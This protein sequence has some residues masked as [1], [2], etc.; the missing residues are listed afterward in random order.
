MPS[1]EHE[2]LVE[3]FTRDPNLAILL[4]KASKQVEIPD[5]DRVEVGPGEARDL[6]PAT[7][8]VDTLI[9]L[10]QEQP[11]LVLLVE[12][13]LNEDPEKRYSWPFYVSAAR[14]KYRCPACLLVYTPKESL[15]DWCQQAIDLGQPGSLFHPVVMGPKQVPK[16]ASVE[17]AKQSPYLTLLA[18]LAHGSTPE[19]EELAGLA[20]AAME[21][22]P[23]DQ[24][25]LWAQILWMSLGKAA[26][27][28]LEKAMNLDQFKEQTSLFQ[29]GKLKGE[30]K[31]RSEGLRVAIQDWCEAT[32]VKVSEEHHAWLEQANAHQLGIVRVYVKQH[33][34]FPEELPQPEPPETTC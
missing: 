28:A 14:R 8:S 9:L 33:R 1:L 13:Q 16:V 29:E 19:G 11:V 6:A 25:K 12:V 34:V 2:E 32:G 20:W 10:Y 27:L 24:R 21:Q 23:E 5:Y 30:A 7:L 31:G 3:L 26:Q 4:A 22:F 17:Q 18:A 15:L